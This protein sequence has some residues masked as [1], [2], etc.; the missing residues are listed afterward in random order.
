[1]TEQQN[2]PQQNHQPEQDPH[3]EQATTQEQNTNTEQTEQNENVIWKYTKMAAVGVYHV[4]YNVGGFFADLFGI[5]SPRYP[6]IVYEYNRIQRERQLREM[7]A[8][9]ENPDSPYDPEAVP[10]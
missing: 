8:N 7:E 9:G 2:E 10:P 6:E 4:L 3:I 1:M 5:T